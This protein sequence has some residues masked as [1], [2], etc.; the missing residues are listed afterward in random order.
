M[1]R[2][3]APRRR[4][5]R[6]GGHGAPGRPRPH[7]VPAGGR[8]CALWAGAPPAWPPWAPWA[9]GV[10]LRSG[11]C[12][13]VWRAERVPGGLAV[14]ASGRGSRRAPGGGGVVERRCRE[15]DGRAPAWA[16]RWRA[17]GAPTVRGAPRAERGFSPPDPW[18]QGWKGDP[19]GARGCV[20]GGGGRGGALVGIAWRGSPQPVWGAG[21]GF[22]TLLG[23]RR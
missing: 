20:C 15:A 23:T 8:G 14:P 22:G 2:S 9:P 11:T 6:R 10:G 5:R 13:A 7:E 16:R 12:S 17:S 4:R 3:V 1:E 21:E 19:G 18:R